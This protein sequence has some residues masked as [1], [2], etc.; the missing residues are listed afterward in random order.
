M[1][2][3]ENDA[4]RVA[5]TTLLRTNHS[6]LLAVDPV[7]TAERAAAALTER[8]WTVTTVTDAATLV[9]RVQTQDFALL[10]LGAL[11]DI[12]PAS[13]AA[14]IA[15]LPPPR[16]LL[17]IL[18]L[19]PDAALPTDAVLHARIAATSR[20]GSAPPD[21]IA[22]LSPL[23]GAVGIAALMGDFRNRL[24][25]LLAATDPC[26]IG[27][28]ATIGAVAHRMAGLGGTLDF[29]LLSNAWQQVERDGPAHLPDAWA[30]TRIT[31]A[32]LTLLL[33]RRTA[34]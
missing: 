2:L 8:G 23:F 18:L 12:A 9:A 31:H 29:P 28:G 24:G 7:T 30:E 17:P 10:L 16:G 26:A 13:L 22:R 11:P 15:R 19:G 1:S 14:R 33:D 32:V 21:P 20:S 5:G 6:V 34:R 3:L 25:A 27:E 4:G